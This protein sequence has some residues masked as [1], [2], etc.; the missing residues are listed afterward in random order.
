M[1][2]P[3]ANDSHL[4]WRADWRTTAFA[5]LFIPVFIS[6]GFWQLQRGEEKQQLSLDWAE[7]QALPAVPLMALDGSADSLSHR[8]V[9]LEGEFLP[10][11][12]F[13]LDNRMQQ[14]QYGFEVISVMRLRDEPLLVLVNRGWIAGDPGRRQL[15]DVPLPDAGDQ[16]GRIYVPPGEAFRLGDETRR[17]QWPQVILSL[18]VAWMEQVLGEPV[19]PFTVR[20]EPESTAALAVDWPLLNNSP[21]KHQGYAVQWFAMA[22]ALF[23]AW[24]A[25]STNLWRWWR[26]RNNRRSET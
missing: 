12:D 24:L 26:Q 13:L 9:L 17:A 1:T 23:L 2:T 22:I 15:P 20:L 18:D 10:G 3:T 16:L 25:H 7:R 6:L 21:E 8:K 11:R 19:Y 14:G 4:Y 5:L